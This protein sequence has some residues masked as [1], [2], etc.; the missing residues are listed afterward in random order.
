MENKKDFDC[1]P[2]FD[3]VPWDNK[4]LEW[5]NKKFVKDKVLTF[6]YIPLNFGCV[7]KRIMKKMTE[8]QVPS[9]EYLCLSD[10]TSKWN[11]DIYIAV[12]D[13][14]GELQNVTMSGSFFS[15]VYEGNFKDTKKWC[16]DYKAHAEK[17]GL[18][19][20]KTYM[21]YTTCP[22]CAKKYN[23]NY[24]VIIGQINK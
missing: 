5:D 3:T 21:W 11:M 16:D 17:I 10:H 19:I 23:K 4:I 7:I 13:I 6:F 8:A 14:V 12:D 2:P 1:C 18:N 9:S 24:V 15:K 22:K 20:S